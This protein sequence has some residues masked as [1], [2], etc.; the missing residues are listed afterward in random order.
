MWIQFGQYGLTMSLSSEHEGLCTYSP[1][2]RLCPIPRTCDQQ[3]RTPYIRLLKALKSEN[4]Q[5]PAKNFSRNE[6]EFLVNEVSV[7]VCGELTYNEH[8]RYTSP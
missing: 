7:K 8:Q 4:Y 1:S 3:Y 2:I 6:E 5:K